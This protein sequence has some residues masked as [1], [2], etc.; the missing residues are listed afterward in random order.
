M[1]D[2]KLLEP[3]FVSLQFR[4]GGTAF[5]RQIIHQI[6]VPKSLRLPL[7]VFPS[8]IMQRTTPHSTGRLPLPPSGT[9]IRASI[10]NRVGQVPHSARPVTCTTQCPTTT[11]RA[12]TPQ[13]PS[14]PAFRFARAAVRARPRR[15]AYPTSRRAMPIIRC[16]SDHRPYG[17]SASIGAHTAA[18]TSD[19]AAGSPATH[20][21]AKSRI[22]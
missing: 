4:N 19:A 16:A 6:A 20:F 15:C 7:A 3:G 14:R 17:S 1:L 22:V 11:D 9:A 5:H 10:Q 12:T 18:V 21:A 13:N 8:P 2:P